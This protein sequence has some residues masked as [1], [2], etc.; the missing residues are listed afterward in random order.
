MSRKAAPSV[1]LQEFADDHGVTVRTVTNWIADGM[2]HRTWRGERRVVRS[3]GNA[4]RLDKE[5][6]RAA[7]KAAGGRLDKDV[8][9]AKRIRVDRM[10]RELEL[11][12]R[13]GSLIPVEQFDVRIDRIIGGFAAVAMGQLQP[14]ER[15]MGLEP[16]VARA[17]TL[18]IQE[19]LMQGAQELA[20][21]LD[22][23]ADEIL[24][25]AADAESAGDPDP[26]DPD[27]ENSDSDE[28][29]AA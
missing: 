6:E 29:T 8:E 3:E 14:F 24:R 28:V 15:E 10:I 20:D 27:D 4:W 16:P 25:A 9:M 11:K 13:L 22:A 1:H 21:Q 7:N 18:R 12:K 19:A 5:R 23:E 17:L 2:P 26:D